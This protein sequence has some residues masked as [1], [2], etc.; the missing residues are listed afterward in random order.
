MK[1]IFLILSFVVILLTG[2]NKEEYFTCTIDLENK[3]D[4]YNLNATYKIYYK[5]SLVT[6]IEKEE[7]YISNNE[8]TLNYFNEFKNLEYEKLNKL[9]GGITYIVEK[10]D[11]K[12]NLNASID[13]KELDIKKMLKDKYIDSNYVVSNRIT[14][15]GIRLMYESKGATCD[16]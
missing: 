5:N 7:T 9:Y 15:G 11:E 8:D 12:V 10:E 2:C 16:M 14:T 13:T 4:E 6:K 1:R 3:I